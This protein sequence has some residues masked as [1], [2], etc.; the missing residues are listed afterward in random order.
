MSRNAQGIARIRQELRERL[1]AEQHEGVWETL[2]ALGRLAE[3]ESELRDEY[4]RWKLR[5]ELLAGAG[6]AAN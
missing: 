4:E 6:A 2:A 5:F 3:R 1:M